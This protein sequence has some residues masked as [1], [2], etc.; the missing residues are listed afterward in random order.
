MMAVNIANSLSN[1]SV[2]SFLCATRT[3]GDLKLKLHKDI[4]YLFLNRNGTFDLN[5]IFILKKFIVQHKIDIIHAHSSSYFVAIL[6]KLF[7]P[8]IKI[9]W[10]DHY[11]NSEEL[12]KRKSQPLKF[13]SHYFKE[14]I[15][16]N[17]LLKQWS[18]NVLRFG[19]VHYLSNYAIFKNTKQIKIL[20]G[21]SGKRL[22]CVAG[23][24]PQKDHLTLLKAFKKSHKEFNDW[25][26]HL[27]GNHYAD[28]YYTSIINY[29]EENKLNEIVYLYHGVVDIESVL[30]ESTIGILS[31]KSEGLPVSLLEYG[32]AKLPVI[33]TDV[34]ECKKV[35][36]NS[37]YGFVVPKEDEFLL[38][39]KIELLIRDSDLRTKVAANFNKHILDNYSEQKIIHK[40]LKIYNS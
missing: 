31:S 2:D 27:I 1:N 19:R 28:T 16:V 25:S 21:E 11:G 6:V 15:V 37:D 8:K 26:L 17:N 29:I 39:S 10:H 14:I 3:E 12:N 35:V 40:L 24:R 34:G 38:A 13:L 7:Y 20:K 4:G 18:E 32:L 22:V 5:A 33:V 9:V 30:A 36:L 23:L